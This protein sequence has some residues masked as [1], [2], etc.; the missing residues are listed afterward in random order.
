MVEKNKEVE[1]KEAPVV[2]AIIPY[3]EAGNYSAVVNFGPLDLMTDDGLEKYHQNVQCSVVLSQSP[4]VILPAC[5]VTDPEEDIKVG[6]V[7][8]T[9]TTDMWIEG[10]YTPVNEAYTFDI[11][12]ESGGGH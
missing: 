6:T 11:I 8:I 1:V 2:K 3:D 9:A 10:E 7:T 4:E 12:R 5:A